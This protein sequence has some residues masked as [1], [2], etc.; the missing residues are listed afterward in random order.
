MPKNFLMPKILPLT[1]LFLTNCVF[2]EQVHIFNREIDGVKLEYRISL[3]QDT[4]LIYQG[5]GVGLWVKNVSQKNISV[6]K[7]SYNRNP[8]NDNH[9][10]SIS[11]SVGKNYPS[12]FW[13]DRAFVTPAP[14]L[15]PCD[16]IGGTMG[17][18]DHGI[19]DNNQLYPY[20]FFPKGT[21]TAKYPFDS[22]PFIFYVV[23]PT[24]EES[25]ALKLFL[26]AFYPSRRDTLWKL[27]SEERLP[28]MRES[29]EK[30]LQMADRF[31]KSIYA[32]D[33]LTFAALT[34]WTISDHERWYQIQQQIIEKYP[35]ASVGSLSSLMSYYKE[36]D[37]FAGYKNELKNIIKRGANPKLTAAA[38]KVLRSAKKDFYYYD[39]K[40]QKDTTDILKLPSQ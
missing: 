9:S 3:P 16:S 29:A 25:E 26:D 8:I 37:D 31:P 7:I 38:K 18:S 6:E 34:C 19:I 23:E 4:F 22:L 12:N 40:K 24:G 20:D 32:Y 33:A 1:C 15:K 13:A 17:L 11:D 14:M 27:P 35:S 10:W 39:K 21:Y 5:I 30:L 28:L 36:K 2:G